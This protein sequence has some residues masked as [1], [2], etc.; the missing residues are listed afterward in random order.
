MSK[1]KK[2]DVVYYKNDSRGHKID[3]NLYILSTAVEEGGRCITIDEEG[4]PHT[5]SSNSLLA[6][7]THTGLHFEDEEDFLRYFQNKDNDQNEDGDM[8]LEE[9]LARANVSGKRSPQMIDED[10]RLTTLNSKDKKRS[11][12]LAIR[13]YNPYP[14]FKKDGYVHAVYIEEWERLYVFEGGENGGNHKVQ[15]NGAHPRVTFTDA[16]LYKKL[17]SEGR[18]ELRRKWKFDQKSNVFYISI[19]EETT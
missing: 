4:K 15:T 6:N 14:E 5:L 3:S 11:N 1:I 9:L 7:M 17:K 2:G 18:E 12:Q 8:S 19:K 10:V 16:K 13:I